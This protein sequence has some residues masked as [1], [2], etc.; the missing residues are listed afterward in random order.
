MDMRESDHHRHHEE[1]AHHIISD[2]PEWTIFDHREKYT[3]TSPIQQKYSCKSRY[4]CV[5]PMSWMDRESPYERTYEYDQI[6]G[7]D[8]PESIEDDF[9]GIGDGRPMMDMRP[10]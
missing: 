1:I 7:H 2:E 9:F 6:E 10:V 3:R 4:E 8:T 5:N